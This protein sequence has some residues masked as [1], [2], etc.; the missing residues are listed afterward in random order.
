MKFICFSLKA[1]S[2]VHTSKMEKHQDCKDRV[3]N[4]KNV[5]KLVALQKVNKIMNN[6]PWAINK[7][8]IQVTLIVNKAS[9]LSILLPSGV[10]SSCFVYF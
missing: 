7:Y 9:P 8:H 4:A 2:E 6:K 5:A 1:K 3:E 10:E